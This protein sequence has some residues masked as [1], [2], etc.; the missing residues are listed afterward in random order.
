MRLHEARKIVDGKPDHED[1]AE[2]FGAKKGSL[3]AGQLREM[4]QGHHDQESVNAN[5]NRIGVWIADWSD[6]K[7]FATGR[8]QASPK[9]E[10]P[11]DVTLKI[12]GDALDAGMEADTHHKKVA[13]FAIAIARAIGLPKEKIKV[14]ATGAFLHDIGLM[15]IPDAIL[16]KRSALT[17]EETG[18]MR[19]HCFSGYQMLRNIPDLEEIAEIVYSHQEHFD[20]AGYPRGLKGEQIPIGAR[21]IAIADTLDAIISERP[22]RAAQS[23]SVACKEVERVSGQ[24]FDPE[25]VRAFLTMPQTIWSD[26]REEI[27]SQTP[28]KA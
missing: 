16:Q 8:S 9:Q 4:M 14:I 19:A 24:Q 25:I 12:L 28:N 15:S 17:A 23:V 27:D 10:I 21:I 5:H 22:H 20:G 13:A 1:V 7:A 18:L 2:L 26:L 3:T 6:T 11:F